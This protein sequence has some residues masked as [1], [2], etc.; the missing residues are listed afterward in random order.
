M[1]DSTSLRTMAD[2]YEVKGDRLFDQN[3]TVEANAAWDE[4]IKLRTRANELDDEK[5]RA[6]G[7]IGKPR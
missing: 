7:K 2:A 5:D 1:L 6:A 3:R 4:M